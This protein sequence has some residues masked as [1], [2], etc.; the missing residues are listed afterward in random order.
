MKGR[1]PS[2]RTAFRGFGA[3]LLLLLTLAGGAY[4]QTP[5]EVNPTEEPY[6]DPE[7]LGTWARD[8][9]ASLETPDRDPHG[10]WPRDR[11][12][13]RALHFLSV[14]SRDRLEEARDSL[15]VLAGRYDGNERAEFLLTAFEGALEVVRAKHARWPPNKLKHLGAGA[16]LLDRVVQERPEDPEARYLRFSSYAFLP[17]F[18][19]RDGELKED[20]DFLAG[21]LGD[22]PPVFPPG[23]WEAVVQS[24]LNAGML[25]SDQRTILATALARSK[26]G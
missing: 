8:Y 7:G 13:L 21:T 19:R 22:V 25:N 23:V 14:E 3:T 17:F 24:V 11:E 16:D 4:S 20:T 1:L 12:V 9:L 18:L 6:L 10:T 5:D 15:T 2:S 26:E